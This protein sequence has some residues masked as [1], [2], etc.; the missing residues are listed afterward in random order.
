M[1]RCAYCGEPIRGASIEL[2][3]EVFCSEEC[4]DQFETGDDDDDYYSDDYN[5]SD[6]DS[7]YQDY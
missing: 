4:M 3:D 7:I 6:D 1:E 2:G 5:D